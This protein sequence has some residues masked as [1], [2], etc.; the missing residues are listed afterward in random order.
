MTNR[1]INVMERRATETHG[2][3]LIINGLVLATALLVTACGGGGGGGEIIEPPVMKQYRMVQCDIDYLGG[4]RW[5]VC[6]YGHTLELRP[7]QPV[8]TAESDCLI[9]IEIEIKNDPEVWDDSEEDRQ[10]GWAYWLD[11]GALL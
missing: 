6:D 10:R 11:C 4:E 7:N 2:I 3:K 5:G 8:F 9:A 1:G